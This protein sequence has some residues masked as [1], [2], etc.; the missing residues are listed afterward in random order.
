ML[1]IPG[2]S[3]GETDC[4]TEGNQSVLLLLPLGSGVDGNLLAAL[5]LL[6]VERKSFPRCCENWTVCVWGVGVWS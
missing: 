4:L 6:P 2:A 3:A 1:W 5:V